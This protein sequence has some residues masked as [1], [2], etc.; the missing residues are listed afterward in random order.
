M[1]NA[2]Q[3]E[4]LATDIEFLEALGVDVRWDED[5]ADT[6]E[7]VELTRYLDED[8]WYEMDLNPAMPSDRLATV[9][10]WVL[11]IV[12]LGNDMPADQVPAW[13]IYPADDDGPAQA[14]CG[15]QWLG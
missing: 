9:V 10:D 12:I 7:I 4:Q 8:A 13:Q 3:T 5:L 1:H 6:D 15:W 2:T 14:R 11:T